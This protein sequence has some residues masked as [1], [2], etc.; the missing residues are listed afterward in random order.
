MKFSHSL[1]FNTVPEWSDKYIAYNFLK[2]QLYSLQ[3]HKLQAERLDNETLHL[4]SNDF[5]LI[6]EE[7]SKTFIS[8]LD[9]E[10]A[11]VD[12]FYKAQ[13]RALF[14]DISI[15]VSDIEKFESDS[16]ALGS[17]LNN[18]GQDL[19]LKH[20]VS[21]KIGNSEIYSD[22]SELR[23][24]FTGI[25][26]SRN[27][28]ADIQNTSIDNDRRGTNQDSNLLYEYLKSPKLHS[29]WSGLNKSSSL[30]PSKS[31]L[32]TESKFLFRKRVISLFT[33]ASELKSY[34]DLNYTGFKKALKKYDKSLNTNIRDGYLSSLP[35]KSYIFKEE[36]KSRIESN[37]ESL[38]RLYALICNHEDLRTA[39]TEL[40]VYLRERVVWG[41]N[42]I[43]RDMMEL[44]RKSYT[45]N[46]DPVELEKTPSH[47]GNNLIPFSISFKSPGF[48]KVLLISLLGIFLLLF[49]PFDDRQQ[50]NCFSLLVSTSLFWASEA[51]PLFVT[52][53][54]VPLVIVMLPILKDTDG[55]PMNSTDSSR[56]IM[57]SM[58]NSVILL[59]LGGFT[60]A[61]ALSKYHI[62]KF[63]STWILSK[64]GKNPSV[65]LLTIMSI[66]LLASMW[67]SNVASPVLCFTLIQP[68]LRTL[69]R[70]SSFNKALILGIA[71]ASNVGGMASPIA[72]PQNM[73]AMGA[74]VPPPSWGEW[75]VITLPIC[76]LSLISI[77]FFLTITFSFNSNNTKIVEIKTLDDK[78]TGVQWYIILVTIST[79]FLWCIAPSLLNIFGETGIISLL[80]IILLFGPGLLST[81]DFNSYP[82]N[83]VI[84]AMGGIALGKAVTSSGLLITIAL[85]IRHGVEHLSLFGITVTFGFLI[86]LVATFVSHTVAALIII[87][88]V[89]EI[90][91]QLPEPHPRLLIMVCA[92]L[93]SAAMGLPT[94][95]FPNVNAIC[96]TDEFGKPYL[97]VGTFITRGIPSSF[98]AYFFIVTVGFA[99]M[100]V[101]NF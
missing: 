7:S 3:K 23:Q 56:L 46:S 36:T 37:T 49:S 101:I 88:L 78:F 16:E 86:V 15:L 6:N 33:R 20:Q 40:S 11:K 73:I 75:F 9:L 51:I 68:I 48:L 27:S 82:W 29:A 92:L 89:S 4:Y 61:A 55:R 19:P 47:P 77:W 10:L 71:L 22:D 57:S 50:K 65:V 85:K 32:I 18:F 42:T 97:S 45:A 79:I 80:P 83:I 52:A 91:R 14:D 96:M 99:I 64:A 2:K 93:C 94:S 76:F 53:F 39:R 12:E 8:S 84:L 100:K 25:H 98:F 66:A 24:D 17:L 58:W 30:L 26:S 63:I 70:H 34:V 59:L 87:P 67:V 60:L 44:E 72:S 31:V 62:A 43:W 90:G 41:R 13:E 69:P 81:D 21:K 1:Q 35:M 38:I 54:L 28:E 95:G 5:N 74:I